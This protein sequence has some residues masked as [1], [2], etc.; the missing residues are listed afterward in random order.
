MITKLFKITRMRRTVAGLLMIAG[1][2]LLF[3]APETYS[4]IFL[5]LLGVVI[6]AIGI[7]LKQRD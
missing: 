7:A 1:A 2:L 5:L 4:G 6:E 3:M